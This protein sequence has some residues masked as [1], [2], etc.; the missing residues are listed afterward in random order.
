MKQGNILCE[1]TEP[2]Q[3]ELAVANVKP[4]SIPKGIPLEAHEF[5]RLLERAAEV[6]SLRERIAA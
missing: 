4:V 5:E 1:N 6:L 2:N 3:T